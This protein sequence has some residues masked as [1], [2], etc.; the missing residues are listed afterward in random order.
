ME[1]RMNNPQSIED[2]IIICKND[3]NISYK[4]NDT[5]NNIL[6]VIYTKP[7][8]VNTT[9]PML[10]NN[11][12]RG[13]PICSNGISLFLTQTPDSTSLQSFK[14]IYKETDGTI[15]TDSTQVVYLEP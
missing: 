5:I 14:I 15:Y 10:L 8:G 4:K 11:Y 2:I 13:N 12:L 1:I 6:N 7:N 3:Y 9:V